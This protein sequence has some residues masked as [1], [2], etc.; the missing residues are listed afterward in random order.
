MA[1][2]TQRINEIKQP[3]GGYINPNAFTVVDMGNGGPLSIDD[4]N[5]HSS[6]VGMAVD[7]LTRSIVSMNPVSAF[8]VSIIGAGLIGEAEK[9]LSMA[10]SVLDLSADSIT[11]A[12]QLSGYDVCCRAGVERYRPIADIQPDGPTIS[13]I[14]TMVERSLRFFDEYGP[15]VEDGITFLG[16]Y[17]ETVDTGDGDFI[18]TDTLWDFKVSVSSPTNKYTLQLLMYYLMGLRSGDDNLHGIERLGIFN[19]RL[20]KVYLLN[21]IDIPSEVIQAVETDVIGY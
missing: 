17:T 10:M 6:L 13:H 19:P 21:V 4:E 3:R 1:S 5:V 2:V 12:C 20:D 15:V 16:G 9:A 11:T 7:Y 8:K 18:T 14:K